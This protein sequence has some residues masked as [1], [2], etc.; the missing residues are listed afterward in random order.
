MEKLGQNVRS[1]S[2]PLASLLMTL[3]M[4]SILAPIRGAFHLS[5]STGTRKTSA[6]LL[7][8]QHFSGQNKV[9]E[10]WRSTLTHLQHICYHAQY[11][12]V[13]ID[14]LKTNEQVAMADAL[15]QAQGDGTARGRCD[16]SGRSLPQLDP[17]C[18]LL[19]TGEADPSS[20]SSL[21]RVYVLPITPNTINLKILE[22]CQRDAV[23]GE[24]ARVTSAYIQWLAMPGRLE[25]VHARH[26][27]GVERLT[28]WFRNKVRFIR[29]KRAPGL[30]KAD[31]LIPLGVA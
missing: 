18:G 9:P 5:G 15:F 28:R 17:R 12:V 30:K 23:N 1:P 22:Q 14:V 13:L 31:M 21:G 26:K 27:I 24:Y 11:V 3:P 20:R 7:V 29:G 25:Y 4:R 19:S 2:K 8:H 10:S 16:S 6:A